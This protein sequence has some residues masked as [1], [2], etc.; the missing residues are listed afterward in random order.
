MQ[1]PPSSGSSSR[2]EV[3]AFCQRRSIPK[4]YRG[5]TSDPTDSTT[6]S[7]NSSSNSK[8]SGSSRS[9]RSTI[10]LPISSHSLT[11]KSS[12]PMIN[13]LLRIKCRSLFQRLRREMRSRKFSLR[14]RMVPKRWLKK[15]EGRGQVRDH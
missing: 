7:A 10:K 2:K 5:A 14:P 1:R 11:R 8:R 6:R 13:S 12:S 9:I 3:A 15:K 4:M